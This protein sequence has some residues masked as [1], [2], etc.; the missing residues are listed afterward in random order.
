MF[1][2]LLCDLRD[3]EG[4]R[5]AGTRSLPVLLGG[6]GTV[7]M[8]WVLIAAGVF[9]ALMHGWP[10]LAGATVALLGPLAIAAR[11]PRDEA[12]YEWLA[13]GTLFLPAIV[14][15]GKHLVHRLAA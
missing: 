4:D 7:G 9:C 6:R 14:E 11:R 8:L 2:M 13:E 5:A 10:V 12:F 3:M 15:L 1:N